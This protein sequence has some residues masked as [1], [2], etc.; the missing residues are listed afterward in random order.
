MLFDRTVFNHFWKS[1]VEKLKNRR[2]FLLDMIERSNQAFNQ[3][4]EHLENLK[5]L[6]ARRTMDQ[7]RH[8]KEMTKIERKIDAN[9]IMNMFLSVKG[10]YRK[11]APLE[12]R[13][14]QRRENFKQIYSDRLNLYKNL[15]ENIKKFTGYQ[16]IKDA[17]D[18]YVREEN[19]GFQCFAYLN[20]MNKQIENLTINYVKSQMSINN[21]NDQHLLKLQ[22][23]DDRIAK[24]NEELTIQIERSLHAKDNRDKYEFEIQGFFIGLKEIMD[25][26][27]CDYSTL[28]NLLGSY[29]NISSLNLPKF[30]S[31]LEKRLNEVL[32]VVYCSQRVN[33]DIM[34]EDE[35]LIIKSLKRDNPDLVR[36]E[37][38]ITTQQCAECGESEDVNRYDDTI[39]FPHSKDVLNSNMRD[40]VMKPEIAFRLHNLS[41]CNLPRSGIIAGRR[42]AE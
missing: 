20:E 16:N 5:M 17:M 35:K 7:E 24:L 42:F 8:I 21:E 3:G 32:A 10:K 9:E 29:E 1:T 6:K 19:E 13:E 14:I 12:N 22:T 15:I 34:S 30:L 36:V 2:K 28:D 31:I 38:V 18:F 4:A 27:K 11:L 26:L 25:M 39:I 40:L 37:E 33:L 41:K 23:Y